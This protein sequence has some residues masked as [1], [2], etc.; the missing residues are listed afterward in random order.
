MFDVSTRVSGLLVLFFGLAAFIAGTYLSHGTT[1]SS[2]VVFIT[3]A[4]LYLIKQGVLPQ[5]PMP[6]NSRYRD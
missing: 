6:L 4:A 2:V 1:T 3:T 5:E